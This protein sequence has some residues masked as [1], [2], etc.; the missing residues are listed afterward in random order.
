MSSKTGPYN[1]KKNSNW[2]KQFDLKDFPCIQKW[3]LIQR[4]VGM[5]HTLTRMSRSTIHSYIRHVN[6]TFTQ[7]SRSAI[8]SHRRRSQP[9]IRTHVMST[10]HSHRRRGQPYIHRE[11]E[12]N[13]TVILTPSQPYIYT[14]IE[15]SHTFTQT[16]K[17]ATST[18]RGRGGGSVLSSVRR[19]R[20]VGESLRGLL[21]LHTSP[22][23]QPAAVPELSN[24]K[25]HQLPKQSHVEDHT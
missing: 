18:W 14:D 7:T 9:Y 8:H 11:V 13:Y 1:L 20:R 4:G 21:H 25:P 19:P 10:M 17:S 23:W 6:H 22:K 2:T 24:N 5:G 12:V 3:S 15:V 16:S